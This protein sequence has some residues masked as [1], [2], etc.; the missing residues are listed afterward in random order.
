MTDEER[1]RRNRVSSLRRYHE[2]AEGEPGFLEREREEANDRRADIRADPERYAAFRER[3]RARE[4]E[5]F[6]RIKADPALYAKWREKQRKADRRRIARAIADPE[7]HERFK[8]EKREEQAALRAVRKATGRM[9]VCPL[10][11]RIRA[12][13]YRCSECGRQLAFK[14]F[15]DGVALVCGC[16]GRNGERRR[17]STVEDTERRALTDMKRR[18]EERNERNG[19]DSKSHRHPEGR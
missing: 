19:Y 17:H 18:R 8:L 1:K 11:W 9:S 10:Y 7:S 14:R 4:R 6:E 12:S 5:R 13:M 3:N 16:R 2:R 15:G